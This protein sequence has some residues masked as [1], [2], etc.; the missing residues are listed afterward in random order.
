MTVAAGSHDI[1]SGTGR[2]TLRTGRSGP[3]ARV[4][5]DLTIT[6]GSWSGRVVV[7]GEGPRTALVSA[8]VQV[9]S[10][11]IVEGAGGV[12]PLTAF[13]RR[14][15]RSTALRLLDTARYPE[16]GFVSTS[17]VADGAGGTLHGTLTIRGTSAPVAFTVEDEDD[18]WHA[19]TTVRQSAFGIAPYRAFL[20][21]LRL[22]DDVRIDV[23][24]ALPRGV[25]RA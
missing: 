6:F 15:I 1:G 25:A 19:T 16:A 24:T 4:G 23:T 13:D 2:I 22:A 20:G 17:V 3:A 18:C 8:T 7:D 5:H 21:A 9:E 14:E 12:L 10:I 11:E